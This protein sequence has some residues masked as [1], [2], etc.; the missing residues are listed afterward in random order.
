MRRRSDRDDG[1]SAG[2]VLGLAG[3]G[4]DDIDPVAGH[5]VSAVGVIGGQRQTHRPRPACRA[6]ARC[7]KD[8][9]IGSP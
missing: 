7:T 4:G 2:D 8:W 5:Q 1:E 6:A 3:G 9:L